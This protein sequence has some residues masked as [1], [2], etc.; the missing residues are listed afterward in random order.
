MTVTPINKPG[1][2]PGKRDRTRLLLIEAAI[3]VLSEKGLEGTSIDDLMRAAGMARGT[4]YNHFQSRE[5]LSCAVS[6]FIREQVYQTVVD[7]IPEHYNAEQTFICT[8]YGF[9]NYGLKYPKTGWALVRIGG[10]SHWVTGERFSRAHNALK[11]VLPNQEPLFLG[12]IY[13]EGV[14]LMVLRRLL[15]NSINRNEADTIIQLAMRGVG[16]EP[17]HIPSLMDT[18]RAFI[19]ELQLR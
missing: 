8:A 11:A 6:S 19:T 16:I 13:I 10:S 1:C 17:S 3:D 12:L 7:R 4:F 5:E 2:S 18:A 15:E 14:T 9:L